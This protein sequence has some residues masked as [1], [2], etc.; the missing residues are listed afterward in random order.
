ML[1]LTASGTPASGSRFAG[2]DA[3]V[4]VARPL[5]AR[6]S[7]RRV[8]YAPTSPVDGVDVREHRVGDFAR[9]DA[10]A[11]LTSRAICAALRSIMSWIIELDVLTRR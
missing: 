10:Y 2:R 9:G 1:S 3:R 7:C 8:K 6:A 4:D 11:E 5:R